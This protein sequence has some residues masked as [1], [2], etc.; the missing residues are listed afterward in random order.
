MRRAFRVKDY[1][2]GR[3]LRRMGNGRANATAAQL[4]RANE[5][6]LVEL[7]DSPGPPL[8]NA[9]L[10]EVLAA[11]VKAGLWTPARGPRGPVRA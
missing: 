11:A 9:V 4:W 5:C 6:G 8:P 7:R 3:Y 10:K 2:C 1:G